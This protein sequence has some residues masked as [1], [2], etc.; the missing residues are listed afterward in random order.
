MIGR[1]T[2]VDRPGWLIFR[3]ALR[4]HGSR[5]EYLTETASFLKG[6]ERYGRF[7]AYKED[8]RPIGFAEASV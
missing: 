6:P 1:C 3:Q 5:E 8:G 4:P 7:L 2:T